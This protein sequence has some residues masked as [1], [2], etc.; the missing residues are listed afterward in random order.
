MDD[1]SSPRERFVTAGT[2]N[3]VRQGHSSPAVRPG[4][5]TSVTGPLRDQSARAPRA[6]G[7]YTRLARS[8]GVSFREYPD[9]ILAYNPPP[10]L[11][12]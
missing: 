6:D 5:S 11:E 3:V 12:R 2:P 10:P 4:R 1:A 8:A 9:R 7:T